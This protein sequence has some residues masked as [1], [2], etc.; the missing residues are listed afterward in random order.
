MYTF[1][2]EAEL[3]NGTIFDCNMQLYLNIVHISEMWWA[4]QASTPTPPPPPPS[5]ACDSTSIVSISKKH[6]LVLGLG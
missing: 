4:N 5:G 6:M 2:T 3:V 1:L